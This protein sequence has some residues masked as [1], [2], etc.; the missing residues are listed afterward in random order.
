M[1]YSMRQIASFVQKVLVHRRLVAALSA[2]VAVFCIV[3]VVSGTGGPTTDVYVAVA[4]I[5]A[6]TVITGSQVQ[7]RSVPADVVPQGAVT[8]LSGATGQMT[9][10]PVPAGAILTGDDFVSVGQAGPGSVIIPL[11]VSSQMMSILNPGDHISLFLSD[12]T[13]GQVTVARGVRVVTIPVPGSSGMFSSPSSGTVILVEVPE[14][15]ATQITA[16]DS[17]G[18]TTVALE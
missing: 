16:A 8:S 7:V 6:G 1:V 5:P 2:M 14:A 9:A 13:T 11:S 18:T 4:R 17:R 10:G 15:L 3:N 12:T